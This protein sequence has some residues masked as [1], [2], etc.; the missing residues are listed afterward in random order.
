MLSETEALPYATSMAPWSKQATVGMVVLIFLAVIVRYQLPGQ[1]WLDWIQVVSV[2]AFAVFCLNQAWQ[3]RQMGSV[4]GA[5]FQALYGTL[6]VVA[7]LF[8]V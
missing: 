8:F 7:A 6:G 4:L 3:R 2:L 5:T 1:T